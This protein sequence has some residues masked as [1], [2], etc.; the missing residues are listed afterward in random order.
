LNEKIGDKKT[1]SVLD[2]SLWVMKFVYQIICLLSCEAIDLNN[3]MLMNCN[4]LKRV[5]KEMIT[6]Q[7][8]LAAIKEWNRSR[9]PEVLH[10]ISRVRQ[11]P[12]N[13]MEISHLHVWNY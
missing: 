7:W 2:T 12:L 1:T 9:W 10:V 6:E 13:E 5:Q 8:E 4:D 11:R 3:E